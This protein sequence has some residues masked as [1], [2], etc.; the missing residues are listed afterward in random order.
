MRSLTDE[1][2]WQAVSNR[3]AHFDGKFLFGVVTTGIFCRPSCRARKP[4]RKNVRF[5]D[6]PEEAQST[7]LRSCLRCFPTRS[8]E[9]LQWIAELCTHIKQAA[10]AGEKVTLTSLSSFSGKSRSRIKRAFDSVIGVSPSQYAAG[11]R[12]ESFRSEL[13]RGRG[14]TDSL[15]EAGY[16]SSSRLYE[17]I[18]SH[19]GMTPRQYRDGG[20]VA[21]SY[22]WIDTELGTLLVAATDR[23]ICSVEF[24]DD[25]EKLL[26]KLHREFPKAQIQPS[27]SRPND[28]QF[29][30]WIEGLQ[31]LVADRSDKTLGLDLPIDLQASAFRI[32]VWR[33]LQSIPRG[34]VRSYLQVAKAIGQPKA[35]RAVAQACAANRVAILIPCHRVIRGDGQLGG[36]RWGAERKE[37]LLKTERFAGPR[38]ETTTEPTRG[39]SGPA[40]RSALGT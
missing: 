20:G 18:D 6:S 2:K 15:Y 34:E 7:G 5:F 14:I 25:Q 13:R 28:P 8:T 9:D 24:G 10:V 11:C 26:E 21:I 38:E 36:Y 37:Q 16:S 30:V 31:G 27:S 39:S 22:A 32:K 1:Q 33:Y 3:D 35:T 12:L 17:L 23:G 40:K 4:L 29:K 19:L